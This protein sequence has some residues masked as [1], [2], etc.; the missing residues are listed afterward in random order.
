[1]SAAQT[2]RRIRNVRIAEHTV[3]AAG[4]AKDNTVKD[5][6]REQVGLHEAGEQFNYEH[7]GTTNIVATDIVGGTQA[8]LDEQLAETTPQ[9][10]VKSKTK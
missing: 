8:V 2:R 3:H 7:T 5:W 4:S 9:N 10:E 1:L 6:L